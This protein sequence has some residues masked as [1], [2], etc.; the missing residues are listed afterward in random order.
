[1]DEWLSVADNC[2]KINKNIVVKRNNETATTRL[3]ELLKTKSIE[4]F[5]IKEN[6]DYE[7][8]YPLNK[9]ESLGIDA[10]T[11]KKLRAGKM[12][13]DFRVDFHGMTLAEAR[14]CL[15]NTIENCYEEGL[16]LILFIT[17]KG[18]RTKEGRESI[19]QAFARWMKAPNISSRVIKYTDAQTKDGGA[20]AVYVL[21]RRKKVYR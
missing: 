10:N 21:L 6:N 7:N 19:K 13:I 9:N 17:G 4:T 2:K 14:D 18:R 15:E 8:C 11:D 20:G 5:E 12:V 16:R 1:M 3:R